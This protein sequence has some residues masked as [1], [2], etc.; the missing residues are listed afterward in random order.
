MSKA[1]ITGAVAIG[2][3]VYQA[4][5]EDALREALKSDDGK[6]ADLAALEAAGAVRGFASAA[7]VKAAEEAAAESASSAPRASAPASSSASKHGKR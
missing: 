5:D 7:S 6:G 2:R 1:E 3:R 4:G